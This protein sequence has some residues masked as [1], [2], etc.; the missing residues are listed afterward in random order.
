M[1]R[2]IHSLPPFL[3]RNRA[4]YT[5]V[6]GFLLMLAIRVWFSSFNPIFTNL[7]YNNMATGVG[8][9]LALYLFFQDW[10]TPIITNTDLPSGKVHREES[11]R[12]PGM[13]VTGL[14][15]G[16]LLFLTLLL[17]GDVSVVS[18]WTVAPYPNRGPYP[19]PW[20]YESLSDLFSFSFCIF[21]VVS[22]S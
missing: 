2:I 20:R 7:L 8:V 3:S 9:V 6:L 18:R 19:Y 22:L 21:N 12:Y 1:S 17:F 16:A 5:H 13:V 15:F 4:I 10:R 11:E 14:G